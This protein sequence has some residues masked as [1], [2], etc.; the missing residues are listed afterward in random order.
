MKNDMSQIQEP[1]ESVDLAFCDPPYGIK[2]AEW[3]TFESQ[4]EYVRWSLQWIEQAAR[5]LKPT[6]TLYICGFSEILADLKLPASAFF[7]GCR[8]LV[9]HYK[10]KANLGSDPRSCCG[11]SSSPPPTPATSSSTPS[12]APAPPPSSPSS[13]AA[14]GSAATAPPNTAPGPPNASNW[15]KTGPSKSGY[16]TTRKTPPAGSQSGDTGFVDVV[17][18]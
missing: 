14:A 5:V 7:Q 8:W 16:A 2:K 10:N 11:P 15:W 12:S 1:A 17:K 6:G 9:W 3:D 4:Q 13:S 18:S